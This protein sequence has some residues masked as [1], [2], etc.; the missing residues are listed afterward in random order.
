MTATVQLENAKAGWVKRI[1]CNS[2]QPTYQ[3]NNN[4]EPDQDTGEVTRAV[5][6]TFENPKY[7]VQGFELNP[8]ATATNIDGVLSISDLINLH[9]STDTELYLIVKYGSS[10]LPGGERTL[11]STQSNYQN[12]IPVVIDEV[13]L[14]ISSNESAQAYS[15]RGSITFTE[16]RGPNTTL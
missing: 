2:V 12:K 9:T 7:N 11:P 10:Q 6:N 14:T 1:S 3:K 8:E 5:E 13:Q 16:T 4:V 15:P